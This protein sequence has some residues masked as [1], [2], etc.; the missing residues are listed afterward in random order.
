[1]NSG[2]KNKLLI[3]QYQAKLDSKGRLFFPSKLKKVVGKELIITRGYENSL[4]LIK[5]T[6]W[7]LI[8]KDI[9]NQPFVFGPARETAR[10]ILGNA[11]PI[12]L[13]TQG[14]FLFPAYLKKYA[15]I[16]TQVVFLGLGNYVEIWDQK[17]WDQHQLNLESKISS[18]S[19]KIIKHD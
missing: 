6:S 16:K 4:I 2:A 17:T 7:N 18:L 10:F 13:D 3:G 12:T 15:Q 19:E 8:T 11:T 9:Q 1:M 14:R 5:K